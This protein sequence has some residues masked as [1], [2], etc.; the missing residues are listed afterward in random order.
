M[1]RSTSDQISPNRRYVGRIN[2]DR[3][4]YGR[5]IAVV[6]ALCAAFAAGYWLRRPPMTAEAQEAARSAVTQESGRRV[7]YWYDPMSPS[8]RFDK[9]GKSPFM[10]M[11]LTPRYADDSPQDGGVTVSARQ[12]QNLGV[13]LGAAE[14]RVMQLPFEAYG[15]VS[16]DDRGIEEIPARAN[17]LVEKLYVRAEQQQVRKNQPLARLWVPEWSAAQEEYLAVRHLGDPSLSAAARRRLQLLFMPDDIIRAMEKSGRPQ[18]HVEVRA[19]EQG[20]ISKLLVREGSQVSASQPMFELSSLDPV[21]VVADYPESQAGAVASGSE[22]LAV[23][24]RWP[25]ET[26]HGRI[27]E[28]LPMVDNAT[29]TYRARIALENHDGKLQPGMYMNVRQAQAAQGESVLAVPQDALIQTGSRNTVLL[30]NGDGHF[31]PKNI[32]AGREFGD[33]VE[34]RQ[35]LAE[36]D[37]VV[38]SGQFLIDSEASLRSALPQMADNTPLPA[39]SD[40]HPKAASNSSIPKTADDAAMKGMAGMNSA[41]SGETQA[42]AAVNDAGGTIPTQGQPAPDY[43][44]EGVVDAVNGD[45]VTLSHHAVPGLNWPPMTMDFILPP[46]GLP[47][48]V[49]VGGHVTFHF[50]LDDSGAHITQMT[51]LRSAQ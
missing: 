33:W 18:T 49:A 40:M 14:R 8:Q 30:A 24:A 31:T 34:V 28:I 48:G 46:G 35:G 50:R 26:F 10:D 19:P 23:T 51:P 43:A 6:L 15:A 9:P 37:K 42:S 13:R 16:V 3:N 41:S 2:P 5:I 47:A 32:I 25:G 20:F 1:N 44:T 27:A 39:T 12:Q 7:L 38:T 45:T 4:N 29:R 36:G 22:L 21:W 11:P 17:G